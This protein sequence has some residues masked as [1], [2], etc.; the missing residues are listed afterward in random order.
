MTD[1]DIML[2]GTAKR[3]L[4]AEFK[5]VTNEITNLHHRFTDLK[6][7]TDNQFVRLEGEI[8]DS[9]T[10]INGKVEKID[11]SHKECRNEVMQKFG[12]IRYH[13]GFENGIKES[14]AKHKKDISDK[15]DWSVKKITIFMGALTIAINIIFFYV[16]NIYFGR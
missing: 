10:V 6:E 13:E 7:N 1:T 14:E 15:K 9:I 4:E 2:N 11:E 3:W 5:N 16:R 8:K 12:Q